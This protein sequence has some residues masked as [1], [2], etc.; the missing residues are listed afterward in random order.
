MYATFPES[1]SC[2]NAFLKHIRAFSKPVEFLLTAM[3]PLSADA[4]DRQQSSKFQ[5][6]IKQSIFCN[7]TCGSF[8]FGKKTSSG[9]V[10]V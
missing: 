1:G 6:R 2:E 4:T 10:D 7:Y 3:F 5:R 8:R 9:K